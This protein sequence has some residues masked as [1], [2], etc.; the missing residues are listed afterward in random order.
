MDDPRQQI[1]TYRID[2][3][4]L[5]GYL[6]NLGHKEGGSKAAL[7]LTHNFSAETLRLTLLD[8][9]R[10]GRFHSG[11]RRAFGYVFEIRD[12]V[13]TPIQRALDL[14]TIWAVDAETPTLAR[15]VTAYPA[16]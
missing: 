12:G 10:S 8:H 1:A 6:L 9:A 14:R 15:L 11:E 16:T 3:A 13:L 5:D 7:L 4:K 2:D